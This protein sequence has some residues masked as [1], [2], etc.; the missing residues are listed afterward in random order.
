MTSNLLQIRHKTN[1]KSRSHRALLFCLIFLCD[2]AAAVKI[3]DIPSAIVQASGRLAAKATSMA[4]CG[5]FT[6]AEECPVCLIEKTKNKHPACSF[7][8]ACPRCIDNM[9]IN[10]HFRCPTCRKTVGTLSLGFHLLK[11]HPIRTLSRIRTGTNWKNKDGSCWVRDR[12]IQKYKKTFFRGTQRFQVHLQETLTLAENNKQLRVLRE[13]WTENMHDGNTFTRLEKHSKLE[14]RTEEPIVAVK[15][16]K[17][18]EILSKRPTI[19]ELKTACS[20]YFESAKGKICDL[21]RCSKNTSCSIISRAKHFALS[22]Y[23]R[24]LDHSR[25]L[26]TLGTLPPDDL[27]DS[28]P[29]DRR[30]L[31]AHGSDTIINEEWIGDYVWEDELPAEFENDIFSGFCESETVSLLVPEDIEDLPS[32]KVDAIIEL[33]FIKAE[34]IEEIPV[35]QASAF[36]SKTGDGISLNFTSNGNDPSNSFYLTPELGESILKIIQLYSPSSAR[37]IFNR[38]TSLDLFDLQGKPRH[39]VTAHQLRSFSQLLRS[40]SEIISHLESS[41]HRPVLLYNDGK[42]IVTYNFKFYEISS[43]EDFNELV[44]ILYNNMPEQ[45][46]ND[47]IPLLLW[48]QYLMTSPSRVVPRFYESHQLF[49]RLIRLA[50]PHIRDDISNRCS[51]QSDT[52]IASATEEI[53][54]ETLRVGIEKL[55]TMAHPSQGAVN[56][57]TMRRRALPLRTRDS[58]NSVN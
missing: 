5:I 52:G 50:E 45:I 23:S 31:T 19:N 47:S 54:T 48:L 25:P 42:Y 17:V 7:H 30:A 35:N 13:S 16:A 20:S 38:A 58:I 41:I 12:T 55:R 26:T 40:T 32:Y 46:K 9:Y 4:T 28:R 11:K 3:L 22:I 2:H 53:P 10:N 57:D 18:A 33:L 51:C 14:V 29:Y 6:K 34:K 56:T 24:S 1:N 39:T 21:W 37:D 27:V 44:E 8:T 43:N 49:N 36:L 15:E